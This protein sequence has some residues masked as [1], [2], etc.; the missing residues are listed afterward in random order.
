MRPTSEAELAENIRAAN[1]PLRITGGFAWRYLGFLFQP[2][3]QGAL[4]TLFAATDPAARPGGYY[5]PQGFFEMRGEVGEASPPSQSLDAAVARRL[6]DVS[7]EL[8]GVRFP[9]RAIA[10]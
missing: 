2:V 3:S 8:S 4:P 6:W 9:E 5:G 1:G 7:E 10:A